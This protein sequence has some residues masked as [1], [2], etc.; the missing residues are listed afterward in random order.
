MVPRRAALLLSVSLCLTAASLA[1]AAELGAKDEETAREATRLYKQGQ[2]EEAAKLYAKLSVDHPDMPVFERNV[3]ACFYYLHKPEP[4]L[5]NLRNYL[6]HKKDITPDDKAV[7]DQ[8]I[9][10][11]EKLHAQ[12]AA[13]RAP[14]APPPREEPSFPAA[15][16]TEQPPLPAAAPRPE[17]AF[18]ALP[19]PAAPAGE[20]TVPVASPPGP[21]P[22]LPV[23]AEAASKPAGADL[24]S[25]PMPSDTG[26]ASAPFYR[27]VW[28]WGTVAAVVVAGTVT[29]VVLATRKTESNV[30]ESALGNQGAL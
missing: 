25:A 27:R 2:Y 3:G 29:A 22:L 16:P 4:A 21:P 1:R 10:E 11:M 8:W 24:T 15:L 12:N 23:P 14:Q 19:P 26:E 18:P 28:F 7:V 6:H 5:S 9:A 13:A 20:A 30:P 17:P